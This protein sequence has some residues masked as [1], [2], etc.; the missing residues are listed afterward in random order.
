MQVP[1]HKVQCKKF[2][3]DLRYN[4]LQTGMKLKN[5]TKHLIGKNEK[6]TSKILLNSVHDLGRDSRMMQ[7]LVVGSSVMLHLVVFF[8]CERM[9]KCQGFREWVVWGRE[10][11]P[12]WQKLA[13]GKIGSNMA[14]VTG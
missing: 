7:A 12:D 5:K 13:V 4:S 14:V 10:E 6:Y 2:N 1:R 3:L 8:F 11:N 9:P